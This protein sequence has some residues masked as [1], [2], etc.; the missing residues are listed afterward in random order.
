MLKAKFYKNNLGASH[1][2][3]KKFIFLRKLLEN[4]SDLFYSAIN[5]NIVFRD[6]KLLVSLQVKHYSINVYMHTNI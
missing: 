1:S 5:A 3:Q 2:L 6:L 4:A